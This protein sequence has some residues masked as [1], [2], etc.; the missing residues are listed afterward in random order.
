MSKSPYEAGLEARA[1]FFK[2]LAHPVR[3]LILSLIRAK[4]RHGEELAAILH[5]NP[6]TI[7][8]HLSLMT[9]AGLLC[10]QKDQYYQMYDLAAGVLDQTLAQLL[11]MS[12][13]VPLAGVDN[14]AYRQKVLRTFIKHGRLISIPS[15]LKKRQVILEKI[16]EQFEPGR[17]Y[18]EK[19]V[20]IILLD[21]H[22]DVASLRRGL[23]EF[24]LMER[25]AGVYQRK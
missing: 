23:I 7:S 14:D 22:D 4:P 11:V 12:P 18:S 24:G 1:E 25:Q 20:N 8:H 13:D 6:A 15:Q 2:A 9:D 17:Q 21:Y 5:L 10:S 16:V 19:D 3:L